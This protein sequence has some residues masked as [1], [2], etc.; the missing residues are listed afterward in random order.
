MKLKTLI[1][2]LTIVFS[3]LYCDNLYGKYKAIGRALYIREKMERD[4]RAR[5]MQA[6]REL[7]ERELQAE[8]EFRAREM[9]AERELR[10]RE[11]RLREREL[12]LRE[13][14]S[15]PDRVKRISEKEKKNKAA[16]RSF[17]YAQDD[18]GKGGEAE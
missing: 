17:D 8:R 1:A 3:I 10:E 11:L 4:A 13:R 5:E 12:Q 9:Q 6:E 7:R 18:I 14:E 15:T 2:F 16:G